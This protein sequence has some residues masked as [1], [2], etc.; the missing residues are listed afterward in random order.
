[1]NPGP[2]TRSKVRKTASL[3]LLI[4]IAAAV[5]VFGPTTAPVRAQGAPSFTIDDDCQAFAISHNNAIVFAVPR[6][7]SFK[8]LVIERDDISISS[9]PGKTRKI[10]EA[11]KFMPIPPPQGFVVNSLAW[12]PDGRRFAADITL[13]KPPVDFEPDKKKKEDSGADD[14]RTLYSVGGGPAVALF[15]DDGRE[16][17]VAGSQSR[18]IEGATNATWL[19]DGNTVVYLTTEAHQ[20]VRVRPADGQTTKLF[21]GRGFDAVVWDAANN[22]AFAVTQNLNLRGRMAIVELDLLHETIREVTTLESYRASL[23]LSPSGDKI[24]FFEDGDTI[25]VVDLK[26]STKITRVR[27]GLGRFEWSWDERRVLLKRA[28]VDQ[29]NILFW[30]GLYDG[31]FT[32]I[33]HGLAYHDFHIAPDGRFL[34]VTQPGKK[35][36]TMYPLQ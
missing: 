19:A 34:G 15:D 23:S 25:D 24:A 26:N 28:P 2:R 29:S 27:T 7:K 8:R 22:R 4:I 13:Q 6:K 21:E 12:A 9:G 14:D 10:V 35:V 11:D 17:K 18:F 33:L 36:L 5:A 30:V 1:V 31:S 16:I 3:S 20:I 32:P